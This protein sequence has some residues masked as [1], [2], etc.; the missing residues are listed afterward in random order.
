M[1]V[2]CSVMLFKGI[3]SS[4]REIK[5]KDVGKIRSNDQDSPIDVQK[6]CDCFKVGKDFGGANAAQNDIYS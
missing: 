4:L 2:F 6:I 3:N 5:S 1:S